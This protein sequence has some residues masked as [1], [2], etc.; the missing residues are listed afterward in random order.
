[1]PVAGTTMPE[2]FMRN[3]TVSAAAIDGDRGPQQRDRAGQ[4]GERPL[5]HQ[6]AAPRAAADDDQPRQGDAADGGDQVPPRRQHAQVDGD[7]AADDVP[8]P[9]VEHGGEEPA[10]VGA[11]GG[12][13]HPVEHREP[14]DHDDADQRR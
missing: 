9:A 10:Q 14:A 3:P 7:L 12:R 1:M 4:P 11:V 13:A 5:T 8:Q 6:L 2:S